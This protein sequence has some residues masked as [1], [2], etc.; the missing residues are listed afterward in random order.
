M[1]DWLH[2]INPGEFVCTGSINVSGVRIKCW[3][4][5]RPHGAQSLK[6]ALSN[7]CNPVFIGLRSRIRGE[8]IL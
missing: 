1:K 4:S 6:E 7:S 3:R 2:Q 5:Y 8:E